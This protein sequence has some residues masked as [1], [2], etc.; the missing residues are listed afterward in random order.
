MT[1]KTANQV[2]LRLFIGCLLTSEIKMHLNQSNQWKHLVISPTKSE[3][4]LV[5]VHYRG[6]DYLGSYLPRDTLSIDDLKK[7]EK[8]I[9]Q[10]LKAYCP[11][12]EVENLKLQIFAQVFVA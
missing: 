11:G 7:I 8:P 4:D 1:S 2:T 10:S 12:L 3:N 5:E 6:K 9:K